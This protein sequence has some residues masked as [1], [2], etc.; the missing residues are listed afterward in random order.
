VI[1]ALQVNKG[2]LGHRLYQPGPS[3]GFH[4]YLGP[5]APRMPGLRDPIAASG[6]R[7]S[8]WCFSL[9]LAAQRPLLSYCF[10]VVDHLA[11]WPTRSTTLTPST[12]NGCSK[13]ARSYS[14]RSS[15]GSVWWDGGSCAAPSGDVAGGHSIYHARGAVCQSVYD[16][17]LAWGP[18]VGVW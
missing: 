11:T 7:I 9:E 3:V 10:A 14:S 4:A 16:P 17:V 6:G 12:F 5:L 1:D 2:N 15:I 18:A 13:A 8:I